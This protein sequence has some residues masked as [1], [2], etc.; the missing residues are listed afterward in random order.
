MRAS[1]PWDA[2]VQ[3]FEVESAIS[4][5]D[6]RASKPMLTDV[7]TVIFELRFLPYVWVRPD[8]KP[9]RPDGVSIPISELGKNLKLIDHWW[10]SG[11][12][13]EMSGR[14]Q[15]RTE[16]S[17]YS[18]GSGL[19]D[20]SSER[21]MLVCLASGRDEH[22]V[23][24]NGT[25]DRWASGRDDTSS[26]WLT[27]NLKSSI[28]FAMQSLLKM[29]WQVESMFTASLHISDF[30]QTHNEAKILT[31]ALHELIS[32]ATSKANTIG[33]IFFIF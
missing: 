22:V 25:V 15:A 30:V 14:M 4:L 29:L 23:R 17:W 27:R 11:R 19:K 3:T 32:S 7:W 21:M 33:I 20:T 26:G 13:A 6:E 16:A 9:R 1:G 18:G 10:T 8:G 5:T 28:F 24:T 12:A 2:D 31:S